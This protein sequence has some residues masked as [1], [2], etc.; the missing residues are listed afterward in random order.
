MPSCLKARPR[1]R[2]NFE[3]KIVGTLAVTEPMAVSYSSHNR[4]K[5]ASPRAEIIAFSWPLFKHRPTAYAATTARLLQHAAGL[6]YIERKSRSRREDAKVRFRYRSLQS[7]CKY[8]TAREQSRSTC[9]KAYVIAKI[10]RYLKL[11]TVC[12]KIYFCLRATVCVD[13]QIFTFINNI[14]R[15]QG[16]KKQKSLQAKYLQYYNIKR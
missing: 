15:Y 4:G 5:R 12:C 3:S 2:C 1:A 7:T 9:R 14:S 13:R 8:R 10:E 11:V 6:A 16:K